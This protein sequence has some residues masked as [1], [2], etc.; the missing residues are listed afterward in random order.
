MSD[1]VKTEAEEPG[2]PGYVPLLAEPFPLKM[3]HMQDRKD[4]GEWHVYFW[5][6]AK[7]EAVVGG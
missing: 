5:F 2:G 3:E 4:L 6:K 1:M 7:I